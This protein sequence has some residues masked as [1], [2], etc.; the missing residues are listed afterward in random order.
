[1]IIT[2]Y[3][4]NYIFSNIENINKDSIFN[5]EYS[6]IQDK[7]Y[8]FMSL[9]YS[10]LNYLL[11]NDFINKDTINFIN[12]NYIINI[13]NQ[14]N[15]YNTLKFINYDKNY[16]LTINYTENSYLNIWDLN[17]KKHIYQFQSNTH[18][19]LNFS[20]HNST[21]KIIALTLTNKLHIINIAANIIEKEIQLNGWVYYS[22]PIINSNNDNNIIT[23]DTHL[24]EINLTTEKCRLFKDH[25]FTY[26]IQY[27]NKNIKRLEISSCNKYVLLLHHNN[28]LE[29]YC[30]KTY[31]LLHIYNNIDVIFK[32]EYNI[33]YNKIIYQKYNSIQFFI[34]NNIVV[35]NNKYLDLIQNN[36]YI[37]IY[38]NINIYK[39][40]NRECNLYYNNIHILPTEFKIVYYQI[41]NNDQLP[42]EL[43]LF[44]F[45]L[46]K[47]KH[48][49]VKQND[50]NLFLTD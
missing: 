8:I 1:M 38:N 20:I 36:T 40:I 32:K 27:F 39:I 26:K 35:N 5:K 44:I 14:N 33:L 10:G 4:H 29:Q 25:N 37:V 17:N 7:Y 22:L 30:T 18:N 11:L 46:L 3:Y 42:K 50:A 31:K 2:K 19:Y 23:Y 12:I 48:I 28:I 45:S 16:L 6:I 43:W 49:N 41:I 47:Y 13:N 9:D 34:Y 21:S 15:T 24:K